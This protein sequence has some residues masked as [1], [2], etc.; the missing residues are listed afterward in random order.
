MVGSQGAGGCG[1]GKEV[2]AKVNMSRKTRG[3]A[4]AMSFWSV[5]YGFA[6][7]L[8]VAHHMCLLLMFDYG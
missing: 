7:F 2:S 4:S 5:L 8:T 6:V 3:R 1:K